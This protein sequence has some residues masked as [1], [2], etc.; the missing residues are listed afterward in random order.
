[1]TTSVIQRSLAGGELSPAVYARTDLVKYQTGTKKMRNMIVL[2]HGGAS[3]RS[4]TEMC[5]EVKYSN[6]RTRVF[7]FKFNTTS[8]NAYAIEMGDFYMRIF[9]TGVPIQA[10]PTVWSNLLTYAVMDQVSNA[11]INY[12]CKLAVTVPGTAPA[13][14]P[15][16]WYAMPASGVYEIPTPF[17]EADLFSLSKVQSADVITW[18]HPSYDPIELQRFGTTQWKWVAVSFVPATLRPTAVVSTIGAAGA[19]TFDYK[20]VSINADTLE[21]SLPATQAARVITAI[22]QANPGVVTSAAHG[23]ANGD[24]V[25]HEAIVGMTQLND[26]TFVVANVAANTYELQNTD[27]TG[28]TAY[29]S[30]GTA[31]RIHAKITAAAT[32]TPAAPN[33]VSWAAPVGGALEYDVFRGSNGRFGYIGTTST[34]SFSDTGITPNT[35]DVPP[36]ERNPFFGTGNKPATATYIQQRLAFAG[37]NNNPYKV[38]MSRSASFH[39][40]TFRSPQQADDAI[41]FPVVGQEIARI[42]HLLEIGRFIVLTEAGEFTIDGDDAGIVL[43]TAIN[44]HQQGYNGAYS[45]PPILIGNSALYVQARGSI[46]RDYKF[47]I[48]SNSYNGQDLTIFAA[49]LFDN[50]TLVSWDY[51]QTPHSIVWGVRDDGKLLGL[52][53]LREHDV[54]GWHQHDT[55]GY[56]E[57]VASVPEDGNYGNEDFMYF[58]TNRTINGVQKRFMERMR[59]RKLKAENLLDDAWFVDCGLEYDG[60]N[61]GAT[62]MTLTGPAWTVDDV[63]TLQSSIAVF[64]PAEIGNSIVLFYNTYDAD[65]THHLSPIR[66]EVRAEI[67]AYTDTTHVNTRV[68]ADVVA[69][70]QNVATTSWARAVD[71]LTGL[72]HLALET[73]AVYGEGNSIGNGFDDDAPYVVSVAGELDLSDTY[74]LIRV[75]LPY[76]SQLQTL[77]IDVVEGETLRDK[78]KMVG[79]LSILMQDTR[80]GFYGEDE[81]HVTSEFRQRD[82]SDDYE[83]IFPFTGTEEIDIDHTWNA[84]GSIFVE[85]HD[86]LPLTVLGVIPAVTIGG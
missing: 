58:I 40:F 43:P 5:A 46:V 57:D 25:L 47:E 52:T 11:G 39:N 78:Q 56:F 35:T 34:T 12:Y 53:Y 86:P 72:N 64:T 28:Y 54:W 74:Y 76:R 23:Y 16:H 50:Y 62:T 59:S 61:Y 15:T 48:Q 80:G 13:A 82:E 32:P 85:Q 41:T 8:N 45:I 1:M 9:I 38:Y 77:D 60:R 68:S 49:H 44:P 83:T 26:R 29:V 55:L 75:G 10:N 33:V 31:K 6:K 7:R 73:V 22:T 67:I 63:I 18:T 14:D 79:K 42:R 19:L 2:R 70:L 37:S 21:Q 81:D 17:A 71:H 66:N 20:V 65:D 84:T 3:N 24:E 36:S 51:Q 27:T 30:G 69:A 4:G